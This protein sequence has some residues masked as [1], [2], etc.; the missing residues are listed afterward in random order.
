VQPLPK[1]DRK[2]L[3]HGADARYAPT[4]HLVFARAGSVVAAPFDVER[5]ELTGGAVTVITDV[6]Q[7]INTPNSAVETGAVQLALSSSGLLVYATGGIFIDQE[8]LLV[9]VDRKTRAVQPLPLPPR[10]YLGPHLSPD[11]Q[12]VVMW[13]QGGERV[14]WVYDLRRGT[15]TRV[16]AEGRN[17]RVIWNPDGQRVTFASATAGPEYLASKVA[18]NSGTIDRLATPGQPSSW[19]PDG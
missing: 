7:A 1:G 4:G 13:S 6:M 2:V 3:T 18:D 19:S 12:Q 11:A 10:A 8:R 14:V 16:T 17:S 15:M 9:W 5:L